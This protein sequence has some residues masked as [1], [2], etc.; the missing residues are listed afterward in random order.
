MDRVGKY[1]L[2][3]KRISPK[4]ADITKE[5][6][7][8]V[9]N[10]LVFLAEKLT[11]QANIII[12]Q[13]TLRHDAFLWL[14]TDIQGELGKHS[15]DFA[16]SVLYGEKELVFPTKRTENLMRKNTCLRISQSA[17]KTLTAILEYFCGQIMEASFSQAKKS[18]RKRIRP[19][20][21]EAAISQ[22]KELHS[23]F[24]KGVISGR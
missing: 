8:T 19:I 20:D 21:I 13:K 4:D 7:E 10:M 12:D 24:G 22:D 2:F 18:K 11:K 16:N 17:V 14:L 3:I 6:L 15:Q 5:S 1:G 9:N 23:M